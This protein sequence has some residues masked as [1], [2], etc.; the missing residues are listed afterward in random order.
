MNDKQKIK[1]ELRIDTLEPDL[2]ALLALNAHQSVRDGKANKFIKSFADTIFKLDENKEA[3]YFDIAIIIMEYL[4]PSNP[5]F[6]L[7]YDRKYKKEYQ[8]GFLPQLVK[9]NK[10][11]YITKN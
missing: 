3:L 5:D 1:I 7:D 8:K 6:W 4:Y 11:D 9:I 2:K 10:M